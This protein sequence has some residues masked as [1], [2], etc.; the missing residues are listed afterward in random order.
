MTVSKV[1]TVP[2]VVS[3]ESGEYLQIGDSNGQEMFVLSVFVQTAFN[4]S[5]VVDTSM[6]EN[7]QELE[8]VGFWLSYSLFDVVVQT[9][10]FYN[11]SAA[12]FSPIRD[13]FRVKSSL[14]D[15]LLYIEDLGSLTVFLCT[16]N[17]VLAGVE[18]PLR[19]LLS[20]DLFLRSFKS[21]KEPRPGDKSE[22]EGNFSFPDFDDTVIS[23]SVAVEFVESNDSKADKIQRSS[24]VDKTSRAID[25]ETRDQD[26][27]D[28]DKQTDTT[29]TAA[30]SGMPTGEQFLFKLA[31]LRLKTST[32][33]PFAGEENI[34]IE[35]EVGEEKVS[36]GLVFC[37]F[38]KQ[39]AFAT[40]PALGVVL[41]NISSQA[42]SDIP[43]RIR[44]FSSVSNHLVAASAG[45][46]KVS[47]DDEGYPKSIVLPLLNESKQSV[48][49]CT[50]VCT[51]GSDAH[52]K[53][54]RELLSDASGEKRHYR[55]C[56]KLKSVRDIEIPG[57][58]S[59]RYQNPFLSSA[60]GK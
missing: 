12:E 36:G 20:K 34:S 9:D 1:K 27:T 42:A 16:E 49:Q 11:L 30:K 55:I 43:I 3:G 26:T 2:N 21:E 53:L 39:Q 56:L 18:I 29:A 7:R 54:G 6:G 4:L 23:A 41:E 17:R 22:I 13:S 25:T 47:Q 58:Y 10:V 19:S 8:R 60:S 57:G 5:K 33:A 31:H 24:Q 15:L 48:G 50:L 44:C 52:Q 59:L 46:T 45:A 14:K 40:S 38:T 35:V 28:D 37:S 32:L 51:R